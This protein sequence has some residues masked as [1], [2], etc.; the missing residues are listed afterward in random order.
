MESAVFTAER[1]I[2]TEGTFAVIAGNIR[3]YVK[4]K[5][6]LF[7]STLGCFTEIRRRQKQK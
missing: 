3:F 2:L 6:K 5:K 4:G 1:L 7:L